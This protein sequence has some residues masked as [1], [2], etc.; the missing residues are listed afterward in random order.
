MIP[1]GFQ[2]FTK[3]LLFCSTFLLLAQGSLNATILR[4]TTRSG[5]ASVGPSTGLGTLNFTITDIVATCDNTN[6]FSSSYERW[7]YSGFVYVDAFG[8]SHTMSGSTA[9]FRSSGISPPCPG[10]GGTNVD[11][12]GDDLT[13]TFVP[14][15]GVG[16]ATLQP[17][18]GHINPKYVILTVTYAPPGSQSN[19]NYNNSMLLGTSS[20][21]IDTFSTQNTFSISESG[22]LQIPGYRFNESVAS[23][24]SWTEENDTSTTI[25]MNTMLQQGTTVRGPASSLGV[26]HDYDVIWLWLNPLS[27]FTLLHGA[28]SITWAGY[29]F[30]ANDIP[31][32]DIY[33]VYVGYL[34]GHF[35]MPSDVAQ[36]LARTWAAGQEWGPGEGPGL[37]AQDFATILSADPFSDPSYTVSV[38][39]GSSTSTDARFTV[40]NNQN[41]SYVPPPPGGN[42]ITQNYVEFYTSTDTTGQGSKKTY[43]HGWSLDASVTRG[44]KLDFTSYLKIDF[45]ASRTWTTTHQ[46]SKTRTD[47][48]GNSASLSVTGPAAT[49]N[50]IGPT[51][52]LVFQDNIYGTFMFYPVS[53]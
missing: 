18:A 8:V 42:P 15:A 44:F 46:W 5:S 10:T 23:S 37:T 50:Y 35:A 2:Q 1:H 3:C 39:V 51:E 26:N 17:T 43:Q 32:M 14:D 22:Q 24:S 25:S 19:V 13:V 4:S 33:P 40:T 27:M 47:T 9:Y 20:T 48:T 45:Q 28:N 30:D 31:A 53:H 7:S 41:V 16:T 38:P 49:D 11:L 52:F 12:T 34:N 29:A 6:R 36:V 21:M